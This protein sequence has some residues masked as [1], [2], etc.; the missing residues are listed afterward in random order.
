MTQRFYLID[1]EGVLV[2]DKSYRPLPGAVAWLAGLADRGIAWRLVSNNTTHRPGD[3]VAALRQAGFTVEP[4][5]L[6]SALTVGAAWLREQ[7]V[8]RLGWLGSAKLREWW[9]A[10]GFVLVDTAAERCEVVVLGVHPEQRIADLDRALAWLQAGAALLCMHRN[11]FWLDAAGQAR[12]GPG[13]W[14]AALETAVPQVRTV[15]AGKPE[16]TI[17]R[18]A[19]DS[20]G[21]PPPDALFISDDPFSDLVGAR[22]LGLGTVFVL[23]GKYRD[24]QVLAGLPPNQQPDLIVE[25]VDQLT[26]NRRA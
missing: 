3:L 21:A 25:R 14:A 17:Y 4:A 24:R 16:P 10:Q 26:E 1:I 19:L 20:L 18:L 13:A 7:G 15:T 6:I 12:L 2:P 9:Q 23:S 22:R 5:H 11:R 8:Q